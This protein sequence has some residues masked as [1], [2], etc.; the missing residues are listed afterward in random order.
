MKIKHFLGIACLFGSFLL[1][2]LEVSAAHGRTVIKAEIT[3]GTLSMTPPTDLDYTLSLTGEDEI[4]P[5]GSLETTI[6]DFRGEKSGWQ[7]T[8][9][10]PNYCDYRQHYTV[11]VNGVGVTDEHRVIIFR[12]NST[13]TETVSLETNLEISADAQA[14]SY[15]ANFEWNLQPLKKIDE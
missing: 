6:G 15:I 4:V 2:T 9:K 5:L 8:A 1:G 14:G 12:D 3:E 10:S 7:L 13:V 11:H